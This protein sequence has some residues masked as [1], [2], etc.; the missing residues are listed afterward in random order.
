MERP[1]RFIA[2]AEL[3]GK[4]RD[5]TCKEYRALRGAPAPGRGD[6]CAGERQSREKDEVGL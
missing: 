6:L 2:Y 4:K 1:N 3:N 5:D